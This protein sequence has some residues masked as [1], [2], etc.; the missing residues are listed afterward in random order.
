M[1]LYKIETTSNKNNK[2]MKWGMYHKKI[3]ICNPKEIVTIIHNQDF[4]S[5]KEL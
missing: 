5:L 3:D 2:L 1:T 4:L